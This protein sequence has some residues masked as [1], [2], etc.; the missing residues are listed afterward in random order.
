MEPKYDWIRRVR[1]FVLEAHETPFWRD[2]H[3]LVEILRRANANAIRFPA[4]S[5]A[6]TYFNSTHLPQYEGLGE[7]DLLREMIDAAR[8]HGIKVVP[9]NHLGA[10]MHY[11]TYGLHPEWAARYRDG[12]PV[13]WSDL[14]YA[15]CIT[16]PG[17]RE[18]YARSV[19]EIVGNYDVQA[20][21]F[22][23]PQFLEYCQCEHC[24]EAFRQAYGFALPTLDALDWDS[25][26]WPMWLEVRYRTA[27][28]LMQSINQA[29]KRIRDI[30]VIFNTTIRHE[31][32]R[33]TGSITERIMKHTQG[34][35]TTEVSRPAYTRP[36]VSWATDSLGM[37]EQTKLGQ[38]MGKAAWCYCPPG[39][40]EQLA[41]YESLDPLLYGV[42]F[43]MHGGTPI[44]ETLRS[45]L[46]DESGLPGIRRL[47]DL[48]EKHGD[49]FWDLSPVPFIA[50]PYSR[51]TGDWYA[52]DEP[53]ERFMQHFRG[54]FRALTHT[55]SQVTPAFDE[56]LTAEGLARYK[57][58]YLE[59]VAC[60]S[61]AQIAAIQDFVRAGGGLIATYETSLY[62]EKGRR[63]SDFGLGDLFGVSYRKNHETVE[64]GRL[65][66]HEDVPDPHVRIV[67]DHPISAGIPAGKFLGIAEGDWRDVKVEYLLTAPTGNA[68]TIA[69]E[70]YLP[71]GGTYGRTF[72]FPYGHP[73]AIVASEYGKGRVVYFAFAAGRR[74]LERAQGPLRRLI[75]N[76]VCWATREGVPFQIEA[77][78]SVIANLAQR[79]DGRLLALH[80]VNFTGNMYETPSYKVDYVAPVENVT[81]QVRVPPGCTVT[82]VTRLTTGAPLPYQWHDGVIRFTIPRLEMWESVV[83][84][85]G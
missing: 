69:A 5:W 74:Y 34:A 50:L 2:A 84:A 40:F 44:V 61:D 48:E 13:R 79:A 52:R 82:A 63:R 76:A 24:Q 51:T 81:A 46:H 39:P 8:P 19:Q 59:N 15:N 28:S 14:H 64:P 37:L 83:I 47:F 3:Q 32:G 72:A 53:V 60:L 56:T 25:G 33:W 7:R 58:L 78:A 16:N 36:P 75:A 23:G 29:I 68:G 6:V 17:F 1:I 31:M 49:Y 35:L 9:Y 42:T 27:E 80:L 55:H 71:T 18:A 65:N 10:V 77:P 43:L 26:T 22:D 70:L 66:F 4:T 11:Q 54:A 12:R 20:M 67:G 21:Y 30:P 73:P 85:L 62:D 45:Y 57:V 41:T 38:A